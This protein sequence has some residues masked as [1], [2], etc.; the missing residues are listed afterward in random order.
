MGKPGLGSPTD[1]EFKP[2]FV[3]SFSVSLGNFLN[4]SEAPCL[5]ISVGGNSTLFTSCHVDQMML[6][7]GSPESSFPSHSH[8]SCSVQQTWDTQASSIIPV[9]TDEWSP[10]LS[11]TWEDLGA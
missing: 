8:C 3:T 7:E 5:F 10:Y 1:D 4:L 11:D 2:S 9:E 6:S